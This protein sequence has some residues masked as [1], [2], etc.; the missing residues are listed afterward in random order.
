VEVDVHEDERLAMRFAEE[1]TKKVP[2]KRLRS[3]SGTASIYQGSDLVQPAHID[4]DILVTSGPGIKRSD[5]SRSLTRKRMRIDSSPIMEDSL[6]LPPEDLKHSP[7]TAPLVIPVTVEQS[8]VP[9]NGSGINGIYPD[10]VP[11]KPD[12]PPIFKMERIPEADLDVVASLT[13]L[14]NGGRFSDVPSPVKDPTATIPIITSI[15]AEPDPLTNPNQILNQIPIIKVT[16]DRGFSD[17][18]SYPLGPRMEEEEDDYG[19]L[20]A[21]GELD[22][23]EGIDIEAVL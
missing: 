10:H 15:S 1:E 21:E 22:D 8:A 3:R 19:D 16:D 11:V 17:N 9:V 7:P 18:P 5:S 20:D 14:K 2:M 23:E 6:A 13:A 4:E 12:S